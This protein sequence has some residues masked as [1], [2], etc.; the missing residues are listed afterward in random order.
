MAGTTH[1]VK[2]G[3]CVATIAAKYGIPWKAIWDAPE[4]AMLRRT[5]SDPNVLA[6]GDKVI[7]PKPKP[8]QEPVQAGQNNKFV[9]KREKVRLYLQLKA[10][11]DPLGGEDWEILCG[12]KKA[13]GT[14][15]SDG[16]VEAEIPHDENE[17]ILILPKRK[18]KFTLALG[19]LDPID[20]VRGA[21]ARLHNL[22][23]YNGERSGNLDDA[24]R[25]AIEQLQTIEK[26][27]VTGK[28]DSATQKAL[29]KI[30]G[31]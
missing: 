13:Q 26:L 21:Q 6:A 7:V 2:A 29:A 11:P 9:V 20:T 12:D 30:Y 24:T 25:T 18:Q 22:G 28:Y 14:T 4:N 5:R 15:E 3:E 27:P 10:G 1:I 23:L 8:R 19:E 16:L 17:A 31:F